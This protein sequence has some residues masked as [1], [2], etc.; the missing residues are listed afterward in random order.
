[1]KLEMPT[2]G[3]AGVSR[4]GAAHRRRRRRGT[5]RRGDGSGGV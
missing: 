4:R 3:S 1:M 5:G 2:S